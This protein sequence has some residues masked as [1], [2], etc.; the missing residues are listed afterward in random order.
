MNKFL[1]YA[2]GFCFLFS[3]LITAAL[4]SLYFDAKKKNPEDTPPVW[5]LV[6][7]ILLAWLFPLLMILKYALII[8]IFFMA[9]IIP[10]SKKYK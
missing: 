9:I 4:L 7:V 2:L 5:Q 8:G 3:F 10:V 1:L 6:V